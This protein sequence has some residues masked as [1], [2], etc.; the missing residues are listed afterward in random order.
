MSPL[1][2][3][4]PAARWTESG[5]QAPWCSTACESQ[6]Y[7]TKAARGHIRESCRG[8]RFTKLQQGDKR[9]YIVHTYIKR[10]ICQLRL[11]TIGQTTC[12]RHQNRCL[13]THGLAD[14]CGEHY[15]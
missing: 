15:R 8:S 14:P 6:A 12:V 2:R 11:P 3:R 5:G 4:L 1:C 9:V 10:V 13:R 7:K